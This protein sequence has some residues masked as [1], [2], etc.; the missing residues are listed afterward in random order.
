MYLRFLV[1]C[2]SC[3]AATV[4]AAAVGIPLRPAL[5]LG[6]ASEW[7][8]RRLLGLGG[9]SLGTRLAGVRCRLGGPGCVRPG[10]GHSQAASAGAQLD[11]RDPALGLRQAAL[12]RGPKLLGWALGSARASG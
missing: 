2:V 12:A 6:F 4:H 10:P 9:P 1:V 5:Q 8:L 3:A 11:S 7:C